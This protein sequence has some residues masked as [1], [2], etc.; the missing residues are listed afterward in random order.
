MMGD[1]GSFGNYFVAA[2]MFL[3]ALHLFDLI[4][5]PFTGQNKVGIKRKGYLA[6]FLLGLI[7][8]VALGP[9]TFAYMAP[10]L[11]IVFK[12]SAEYPFYGA[13]LLFMYGIG[14]CGI[15]VLAG[16][17]TELVQH[18]LNWNEKS[19]GALIVKRVCAVLIILA[20]VY[21]ICTA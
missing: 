15:I 18:Y 6:A 2:I 7:F 10:M 5:M 4:P 20:G 13:S 11:A 3:V 21:M 12:T 1:I 8:G 16:T 19:K 9:C 17:F 14:H